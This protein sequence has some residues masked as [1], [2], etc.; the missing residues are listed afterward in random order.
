MRGLSTVLWKD[1][2][3]LYGNPAAA[4]LL[5]VLPLIMIVFVSF[6]FEKLLIGD[7]RLD[8]SVVDLDDSAASR[9]LT[10]DLDEVVSVKEHAW[11]QDRFTGEDAAGLFGSGRRV[12]VLVI[13]RQ[14]EERR[15]ADEPSPLQLYVDPAQR[16]LASTLRSAVENR[17]QSEDLLETT[18]TVVAEVSGR[19]SEE[20][21]PDVEAALAEALSDPSIPI[22]EQD[23]IEGRSLPSAF[24]QTVPGFTL[25]FSVFLASAVAG[26]IALE[27]RTRG[28]WFRTLASPVGRPVVVLGTVL[29]AFSLGVLQSVILF[30]IGR[31]AFGMEL[32]SEYL[33]LALAIILFQMV[34]AGLGLALA[35]YTDNIQLQNN[36]INLSVLLFAVIGGALL[37]LFLLPDW[38][39]FLSR[40]TPH[41]W[42]MQSLHDLMFR[43]RDLADVAF[44]LSILAV[45]AVIPL[46]LGFL[47]FQFQRDA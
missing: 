22:D 45:F 5:I 32:G 47:R 9:D 27:R 13:P 21:R 6:A 31:F 39:Q 44:K 23:L 35:G 20:V 41:F 46:T 8:L 10:H 26:Q 40:F 12:A 29:A 30:A 16:G 4:V 17:L 36:I 33:G 14:F 42:A 11:D 1:F 38:M 37:P 43:G 28:T 7:P 2:L 19:P 18:T 34:P 3:L 24:E 15:A 25:M